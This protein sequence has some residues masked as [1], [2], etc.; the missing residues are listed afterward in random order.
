MALIASAGNDGDK[1]FERLDNGGYAGKCVHVIGLG[2]HPNT[3][4]KAPAGSFKQEVL[5]VWETEKLME[6]GRP[7]T[8]HKRYTLSLGTK[9]NLYKDLVA[10]RSKP[11]TDDEL[12]SFDLNNILGAPAYLSV[13][14]VEKGDKTY[15][16]LSGIMPLPNEMSVTPPKNDLY[17]FSP[18]DL[19]KDEETFKKIWPWVQTAIKASVEGQEFFARNPN[20]GSDSDQAGSG[21][22]AAPAGNPDDEIPF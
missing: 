13:S 10:W 22:G 12:K 19:G 7:F 8:V 11:F 4:P 14:K 15:N 1:N 16:N 6:D 5:I 20:W 17:V 21:G 2:T 3:H 9:A 18:D